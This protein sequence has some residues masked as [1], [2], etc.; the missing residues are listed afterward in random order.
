MALLEAVSYP[1]SVA[2]VILFG[3]FALIYAF[4][5]EKRQGHAD[6]PEFFLTARGSISMFTIAW[7]FYAGAMGSWALFSPPSYC[8]Y[9][10]VLGTIMYALASGMPVFVV[11]YFG[12]LIQNKIPNVMG[13]SDFVNRRF[14]R[15]LATYVGILTLFNMGVALTAEYTAVGDLF[16]FVIHS[17]RWPI[18]VVIGVVSMAYTAAGGLYVSIITDQ[19]QA[20]LSIL[21]VAVIFIYVAATFDEKLGRLPKLSGDY[22]D[23]DLSFDNY[24]GFAAIPVMPISLISSTFYSEAV[25]QRCWASESRKTLLWGSLLGAIAITFVVGLL[26]FG[27]ILAVWGGLW[28]PGVDPVNIVLFKLLNNNT[29][30]LVIVSILAVT[31][32]ESAVDSLQNAIVDSISITFVAPITALVLPRLKVNLWWIR[33]LVLVLNVPP[34]VVSLKGYNIIQLFLLANLITTTSTLPIMLGVISGPKI[35]KIVTPFSSFSGC[36]LGLASLFVY[37]K[38]R[39]PDGVT[40][41]DALQVTFLK[42]YDYPPFLLALGFSLAGMALGALLEFVFRSVLRL[43]YPYYDLAAPTSTDLL[44]DDVEPMCFKDD[45]REDGGETGKMIYS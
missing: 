14:G 27:G 3:I 11:A 36:M 12:S 42:A 2:V 5:R 15:P 23:Y 19:W 32:S 30:I 26:G 20:I 22:M 1:V 40:Y 43:D 33:A 16:E 35:Q 25:W 45:V 38:V 13:L 24:Y 4:M 18:V 34:I 37:T 7:S 21:A 6:S 28:V 10:G 44:V 17:S 31:M 41:A 29:G 9:S 8:L 39:Q